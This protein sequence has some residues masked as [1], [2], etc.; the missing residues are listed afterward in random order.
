MDASLAFLAGKIET[1]THAQLERIWRMG[2]PAQCNAE[3][4]E[5]N[6]QDYLRYGNHSSV[7]EELEAAYSTLLKDSNRGYCL[8]FDKRAVY[9]MLN[10]HVTPAGLVDVNHKYKKPRPIFDSSF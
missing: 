2:V 1:Q 8:L 7:S 3:V 6:F 5:E 10:C 4:T 9:F